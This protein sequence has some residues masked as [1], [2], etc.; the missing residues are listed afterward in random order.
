MV[1]KRRGKFFDD[2]V[3]VLNKAI[4]LTSYQALARIKRKL[5]PVRLGH[6]GT[7][8]PFASGI[9]VLLFNQAT[10][11]ADVFGAGEKVY[12]A[13]LSLG[14]ATDTGD[15]TGQTSA[16]KPCANIS[17]Q[18]VESAMQELVGNIMQ[19]PP[20]YSAAKHQGKPLYSYARSGQPVH[21]PPRPVTIKSARLLDL[22]EDRL[23]FELTCG[24]GV[25][26]RSWAEDLALKLNT[27]GH[28]SKLARIKN[29]PF[30]LS[31]ALS[32]ADADE[33]GPD[34][35]KE[36]IM[37]LEA[38]LDML[39]VAALKVDAD[40]AFALR[41]GMMLKK[42]DFANPPGKGLAYVLDDEQRLVTV[43]DFY[44][45]GQGKPGRDYETIRVF[46]VTSASAA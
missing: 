31:Y 14:R 21:K 16:E 12:Q 42:A 1:A 39:G 40:T 24:S 41:Q 26:V 6:T 36:H 18:Q 2:G 38:A 32:L 29:G 3:L 8:D 20:A 28:L 46:N 17:A 33:M 11:L 34:E 27:V 30:T 25:Y 15:H 44:E 5:L 4:D 43:V 19:A 9:L 45:P 37:P 7:L 23:S 10:R 35:I 13:E 22:R